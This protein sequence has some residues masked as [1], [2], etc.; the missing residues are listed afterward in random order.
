MIYNVFLVVSQCHNF[1]N[2]FLQKPMVVWW[3][4]NYFR[5]VNKAKYMQNCQFYLLFEQ[6]FILIKLHS[7]GNLL[8]DAGII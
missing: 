8:K 6:I 3:D 7:Y 2:K 4:W 5:F 1:V